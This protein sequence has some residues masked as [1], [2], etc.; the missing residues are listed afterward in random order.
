[1]KS[2]DDVGAALEEARTFS[3]VIGVLIVLGNRLGV[4][5]DVDLIRV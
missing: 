2:E 5:G 1:M 3:G 4:W